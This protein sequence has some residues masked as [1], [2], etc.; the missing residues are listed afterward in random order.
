M[1]DDLPRLGIDRQDMPPRDVALAPGA[2][3]I[4][5]AVV[6]LRGG[7]E[8]VPHGDRRFDVGIA[9]TEHVQ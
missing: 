5:D 1:P 4:Q 6:D 8:P 9:E 7:G 3:D 2:A